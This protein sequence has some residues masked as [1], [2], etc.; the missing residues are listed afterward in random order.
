MPPFK[1]AWSKTLM[2]KI[3]DLY[4]N[5][6]KYR[7]E[8]KFFVVLASWNLKKLLKR[9]FVKNDANHSI[10]RAKKHHCV[11]NLEKI[12]AVYR[13][14]R[15]ESFDRAV[16]VSLRENEVTVSQKIRTF[17]SFCVIHSAYFFEIFYT[18]MFFSTENRMVRVIGFW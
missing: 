18:V 1:S 16:T 8:P 15:D 2:P 14:K 12:C 11:K 7:P 4:F 6:V 13:A 9:I 10:L 5:P 17:V 3:S